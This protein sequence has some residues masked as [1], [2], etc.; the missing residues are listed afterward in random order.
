MKR[1][2]LLIIAA[3]AACLL[4]SNPA[5]AEEVPLVSYTPGGTRLA[6]ETTFCVFVDPGNSGAD[7]LFGGRSKEAVRGSIKLN[8][9]RVCT[10][11]EEGNIFNEV[12][13]DMTR[14]THKVTLILESPAWFHTFSVYSVNHRSDAV[15]EMKEVKCPVDEGD[16]K[17]K[18]EES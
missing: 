10:L 17:N 16:G 6:G 15:I 13:P 11:E 9:K 12:G 1:S 8:G 7:W 4:N 18:R 14:G 3:L 5:A 2:T